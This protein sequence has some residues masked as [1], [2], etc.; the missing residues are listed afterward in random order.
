MQARRSRPIGR[1]AAALLCAGLAAAGCHATAELS[2]SASDDWVRTYDLPQGAT[3]DLT[4]T[5]GSIDVEGV[6]GSTLEVRA[7]RIVRSTSDQAARDVLSR[8]AITE[9]RQPDRVTIHT[10]GLEGLVI[11][12]SL[13]VRYHVRAPRTMKLHLVDTNGLIRLADLSGPVVA[14]TTNGGVTAT[15]LKG[16]V[17]ARTVNGAL[18]IQMAAVGSDPIDLH[19]TNGGVVLELPTTAA[20]NLSLSAVNGGVAVT[21]LPFEATGEQS[22]RR[23]KGRLNGGG[24]AIDL[25]TT[26]GGVR[27]RASGEDAPRP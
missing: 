3:L 12:V 2:G 26:N 18:R 20:A 8:V 27:V 10:Q 13:D 6:D 15:D 24:T 16:G 7:E 23:A 4:N 22:R 5:N 21:G 19:T 14:R 25:S 9:E 17:D 1:L 11:G